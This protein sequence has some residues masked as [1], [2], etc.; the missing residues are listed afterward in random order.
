MYAIQRPV[1]W[2]LAL[3]R[4]KNCLIAQVRKRA[5][6]FEGRLTA[7]N[8]AWVIAPS[9]N[10]A[11]LYTA[12]VTDCYAST[13][14]KAASVLNNAPRRRRQAAASLAVNASRS[15]SVS[16]L[17]CV[18]LRPIASMAA[19]VGYLLMALV[20]AKHRAYAMLVYTTKIVHPPTDATEASAFPANPLK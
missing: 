2:A 18:R 3:W 8:L 5:I 20:F 11:M 6:R 13:P 16:T 15:V 17:V 4:V 12:A 1:Y 19:V 7:S 9:A 10:L 14:N